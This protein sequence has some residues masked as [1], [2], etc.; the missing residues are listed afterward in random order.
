[1]NS[2]KAGIPTVASGL[3]GLMVLAKYRQGE[4]T[5]HLLIA[6]YP[7]SSKA[8]RAQKSFLSDYMS[9]AGEPIAETAD[10]AKIELLKIGYD[11]D[12]LI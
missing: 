2:I 12:I 4:A 7:D 8:E 5:F 10:P 1:V 11:Q 9:G 6:L 3:S